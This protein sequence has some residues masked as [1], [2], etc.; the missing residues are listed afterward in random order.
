LRYI[1]EK[2]LTLGLLLCCA[3]GFSLPALGQIPP[4][5]VQWLVGI[6]MLFAWFELR[7][8]A[9][10]QVQ[11]WPL[12]AFYGLRFLLLP[13]IAFGLATTAAPGFASGLMLFFLMPAGVSSPALTALH[14]GNATLALALVVLSS[15]LT[16]FVVPVICRLL[17]GE[18]AITLPPL[19][20]LWSLLGIVFIPAGIYALIGRHKAVVTFTKAHGRFWSIF[21]ILSVVSI[22]LARQKTMMLENLPLLATLT[23]VS[24]AAFGV[25]Y[26]VGWWGAGRSATRSDKIALAMA[27]GLNNVALGVSLAFL[28]GSSLDSLLLVICEVPWGLA[29]I[30]FRW[31]LQRQGQNPRAGGH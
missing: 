10:K 22:V 21:L 27:S 19:P 26:V 25:L 7:L 17:L 9:L 12:L 3:V 6:V 28:Y 30:P 31:V 15:L 8:E 5:V 11:F 14:G 18:S 4:W 1:V 2:N 24:F 29:L 13:I 20:L 16:P 23:A